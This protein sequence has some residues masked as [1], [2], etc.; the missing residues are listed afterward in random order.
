MI[1][2]ANCFTLWGSAELATEA[3]QNS[4]LALSCFSYCDKSFSGMCEVR[5][6]TTSNTGYG[7]TDMMSHVKGHPLR[8]LLGFRD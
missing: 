2:I 1:D 5:A 4:A 8:G 7:S 6:G 3:D